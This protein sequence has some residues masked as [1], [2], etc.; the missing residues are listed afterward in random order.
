MSQYVYEC[1]CVEG[2]GQAI[3]DMTEQ[4]IDVG[5]RTALRHCQ[6]LLDWAATKGYAKRATAGLTLRE[7]WAVSFHRSRFQ[8]RRCYYICWSA[9]EFVWVEVSNGKVSGVLPGSSG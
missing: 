3:S 1:S 4:A 5:Y 2:D 7:D 8:G 6:G 9:I